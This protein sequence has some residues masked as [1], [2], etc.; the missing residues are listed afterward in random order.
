M[1]KEILDI[2]IEPS[3][4]YEFN[5]DFNDSD[6]ADLEGYYNCYFKCESIGELQFS[7]VGTQYRLVISEANTAL[8]TN[9]LE[10]YSVY[11][12]NTSSSKYDKLLSGRIHIDN[13]VR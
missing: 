13:R 7:V 2:Y 8:L 9:N 4:E 1:A 11:V 10:E 5:L 12:K 6:G 3:Y